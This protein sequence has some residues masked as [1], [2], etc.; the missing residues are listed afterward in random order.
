VSRVLVCALALTG[1]AAT[2][3][4]ADLSIDSLKDPLPDTVSY[5]GVTLYGTIDV[6]AAYQNHGEPPSGAWSNQAY[7]LIN[8]NS[9]GSQG[10]IAN[11]ALTQSV[12]GFKVEEQVGYGFTAIA[13][14]ATGFNPAY[15]EIATGVG[16][17]IRNNGIP[18]AAQNANSDS[19]RNG[20]AFNDVA[21]AGL[22]SS[23][24]G[25]LTIGRI[26]SLERDA[27]A[28]FD[29]LARSYAFSLLGNGSTYQGT[30]IRETSFVDEAVKYAY[31]F[32]PLHAAALYSA[33][34]ADT[35]N[36]GVYSFDVGGSYRSFSVDGTYGHVTNGVTASALGVAPAGFS[37]VGVNAV[38]ASIQDTD[39]WAIQGKYTFEVGGFGGFKD[40]GYKDGGDGHKVIL[41]AGYENIRYSSY[42]AGGYIPD[43]TQGGYNI[44][45]YSATNKVTGLSGLLYSKDEVQQLFWTGVKYYWTPELSLTGAYYRL[46]Q[47]SYNS[48]SVYL[49]APA[50]TKNGSYSPIAA[51]AENVVS[52]LADY[53]FSKHFDIYAGISYSEVSGPTTTGSFAAGYAQ[54]SAVSTAAGLRLKF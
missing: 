12:I 25:T 8:K 5:A 47:S 52:F 13:N 23:T 48:A 11:N 34:G 19:G 36:G 24:F 2:A 42:D 53:E 30:G 1:F 18:G 26:S 32:G 14:L 20:Q 54:T 43:T 29:P 27:I 40:G 31:Q 22:S 17:L 44:A 6:G 28:E 16:S 7:W 39:A 15:G 35:G 33:G 4:A 50:G 45:A 49:N 21:Y 3:Q 46:D 9:Q 37:N 10:F 51:G 41:Y 38:N